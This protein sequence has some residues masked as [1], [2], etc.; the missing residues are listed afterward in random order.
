MKPSR[1][2]PIVAALLALPV[3]QAAAEGVF[4]AAVYDDGARSVLAR[5]G[6][7][8]AEP[9]LPGARLVVKAA[10]GET[11]RVRS[12]GAG[13]ETLSDRTLRTDELGIASAPIAQFAA[14]GAGT[15]LR[16]EE[17]SSGR[18]LVIG[19]GAPKVASR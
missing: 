7:T 14:G 2:A 8:V 19:L 18:A 11:I 9:G 13:G 5:A 6:G 16:V 15:A 12:L 17:G 1:L 10:A 4:K 3:A